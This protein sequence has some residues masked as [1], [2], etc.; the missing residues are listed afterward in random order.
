[1]RTAVGLTLQAMARHN[2]DV[3]KSRADLVISLVFFAMHTAKNKE[4]MF[5]NKLFYTEVFR[6]Y[7]ERE[8]GLP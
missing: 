4:G 3:V 5:H 8:S 2:Q 7:L 6:F 1:M